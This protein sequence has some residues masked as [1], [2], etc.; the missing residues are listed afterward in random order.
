VK[1]STWV[2]I[3]LSLILLPL[4][5][6]V[7]IE[8]LYPKLPSWIFIGIFIVLLP[9]ICTLL[10]TIFS[11]REMGFRAGLGT[12]IKQRAYYNIAYY[13]LFMGISLVVLYL[14][15]NYL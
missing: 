12:V 4:A 2:W 11:N 5:V 6:M 3:L 10:A 15:M 1:S 13:L 9:L 14:V 7:I 8:P